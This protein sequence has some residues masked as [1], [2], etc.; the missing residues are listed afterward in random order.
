MFPFL[1]HLVVREIFTAE[2]AFFMIFDCLHELNRIAI[3]ADHLVWKWGCSFDLR[4]HNVLLYQLDGYQL[5]VV[6]RIS[7]NL[8]VAGVVEWCFN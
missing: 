7:E 4:I 5:L 8:C 2:V 6:Q 3:R 1:A